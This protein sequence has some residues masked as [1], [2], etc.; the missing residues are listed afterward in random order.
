M[1]IGIADIESQLSR[2]IQL[3]LQFEQGF[4]RLGIGPNGVVGLVQ[5]AVLVQ[6]RSHPFT[7]RNRTPAHVVPF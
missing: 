2:A 3:R 7:R 6:Q 5:I 4:F 1:Q